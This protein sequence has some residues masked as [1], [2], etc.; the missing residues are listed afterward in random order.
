MYTTRQPDGSLTPR[1]VEV[2]GLKIHTVDVRAFPDD[3]SC[4]AI[5][6]VSVPGVEPWSKV[7]RCPISRSGS[8]PITSARISTSS[9]TG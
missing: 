6:N 3:L 8:S 4:A 1:F 5:I 2:E 7:V 9:S